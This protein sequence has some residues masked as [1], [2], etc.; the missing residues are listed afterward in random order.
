MKKPKVIVVMGDKGGIGKTFV[1]GLIYDWLRA[2]N[3]LTDVY[4]FDSG[5]TTTLSAVLPDAIRGNID[6]H[7]ALFWAFASLGK[8][9]QPQV[10]LIDLGARNEV[11]AAPWFEAVHGKVDVDWIAVCPLT[12]DESSW[13]SPLHWAKQIRDRATKIFVLNECG[14]RRE[15]GWSKW[16]E[17]EGRKKLV[18]ADKVIE[19]PLKSA[20]AELMT[21]IREQKTRLGLVNAGEAP[22]GTLRSIPARLMAIGIVDPF[23]AALDKAGIL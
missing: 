1:A 13:P 11:K 16:Q 5:R 2:K 12:R 23:Y 3:V 18:A 19:I 4:D 22:E 10:I 8:D 7:E 15:I 20:N 17:Q 9:P 14:D 21:M 6:E